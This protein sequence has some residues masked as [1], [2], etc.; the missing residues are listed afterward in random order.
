MPKI[1]VKQAHKLDVAEVRRRMDEVLQDLVS[2]YGLS[3]EWK[4]D[5]KVEIS[6]TGVKGT[7]EITEQAVEV[8]L[9]LSFV[10]S[11]MKTKI[12]SSLREKMASKLA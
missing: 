10:L 8:N 5:R 9:D 6:R 3:T 4:G 11:P 1:N 12:E 7:A 2:R